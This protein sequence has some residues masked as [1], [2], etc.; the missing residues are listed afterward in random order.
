[1]SGE[2]G[3]T[4]ILNNLI[5]EN[6][7][8][9]P[10]GLYLE[11]MNQ[12]KKIFEEIEAIKKKKKEDSDHY[13]KFILIDAPKTYLLNHIS[14]Q[15]NKILNLWDGRP[16]FINEVREGWILRLLSLKNE[17]L[18]IKIKKINKKSLR[19]DLIKFKLDFLKPPHER[20]APK[21]KKNILLNFG[22]GKGDLEHNKFYI[23][24]EDKE[25]TN[26]IY[27]ELKL[28]TCS[29]LETNFIINEDLDHK[30]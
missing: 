17:Y 11:L 25:K 6:S 15:Y 19:Y 2:A 20:E 4:E 16:Y 21:I 1:M 28:L 30:I 18:F 13:L 24:D 3:Q 23:L 5:F 10:N 9:I 14:H 27:E 29:Y 26:K 8:K 7:E 12:T 22:Y